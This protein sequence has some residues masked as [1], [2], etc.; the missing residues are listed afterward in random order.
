MHRCPP[1]DPRVIAFD[2][3][4]VR[5]R[6]LACFLSHHRGAVRSG[7]HPW[8]GA[9]DAIG[10]VRLLRSG[11]DQAHGGR[12]TRLA[13]ASTRI[14]PRHARI[15]TIGFSSFVLPNPETVHQTGASPGFVLPKWRRFI[16]HSIG[17]WLDA[18]SRYPR[19][20]ITTNLQAPVSPA[21]C[22][23]CIR[24]M[25]RRCTTVRRVIV[26]APIIGSAKQ[27]PGR[28]FGLTDLGFTRDRH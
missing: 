5:G 21:T 2:R 20:L 11:R 7:R 1:G 19:L 13:V 9:V 25:A 16:M 15:E 14:R 10:V 23:G 26:R 27:K 28:P 8:R 17:A 3:S 22:L 24:R 4:R 12:P 6:A 18:V